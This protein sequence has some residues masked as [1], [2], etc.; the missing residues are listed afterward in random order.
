MKRVMW[1]GAVAMGSV[2]ASGQPPASGPF[3]AESTLP[4]HAPPFDRIRDA[5]YAPAFEA[6]M[7]EQRAET[8]RIA[9]DP[10]APTFDNTIVA[11]ERSGQ[12]LDRV[13]HAFFGVV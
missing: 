7:A 8:D 13:Q 3:A 6:G 9:R 1:L 12:M 2:A 10:A 4:F 5:D 11:M